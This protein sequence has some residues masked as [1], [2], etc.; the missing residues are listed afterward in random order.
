[1]QWYQIKNDNVLSSKNYALQNTVCEYNDE[2]QHFQVLCQLYIWIAAKWLWWLPS[3]KA[4]LLNFDNMWDQI[5]M[6]NRQNFPED[7]FHE[8][9]QAN[10]IQSK[11]FSTLFEGN[12]Y[13]IQPVASIEVA[14][15][16]NKR[17]IGKCL[18]LIKLHQVCFPN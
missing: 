1:M 18:I 17:Q 13:I 9:L 16:T 4:L 11:I 6:M 3:P 14:K 8:M 15:I 7:N 2:T 12:K 10:Y 5:I